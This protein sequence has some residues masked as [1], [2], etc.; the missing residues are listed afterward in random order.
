[1]S[2]VLLVVMVYVGLQLALGMWVSRRVASQQDYLLGGRSLGL[3]LC[4]ASMFATWFGAETCVGAA[5]EVYRHGLGAVSADP[6]GYGVCLIAFGLFIAAELRKRRYTTLADLFAERFSRPVER[7]VA[8]IMLPGSVLWAA[9]QI[10]AFGHV[11]ASASHG[12]DPNVGIAIAAA[13]TILYTGS[14]GLLADVYTDLLQGIVLVITLV[15]LVLIIVFGVDSLGDLLAH[16]SATAEVGV[17]GVTNAADA[18]DMAN[19]AGGRDSAS[20]FAILNDWAVPIAGSLFTQEIISRAVASKTAVI[21]RRSALIAGAVYLVLGSIPV[22]LGLVARELL[23]A[24]DAVEQILPLLSRHLLGEVGFV[25]LAGALVSAILSTVDSALLAC[26]ALIVQNLVGERVRALP[27]KARLRFTRASVVALGVVAFGLATLGVS[28]HSLVEE[29]AALG[30][31]G[32]FV[33]GLLG[34]FTR[35]GGARAAL[36]SIL[37]GAACYV[38]AEHIL[39]SDVSYLLSL[40]GALIGYTLGALFEP[41][42]ATLS[43][44]G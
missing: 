6:F 32:L 27:D 5:G 36:W 33:A 4:T 20:S 38:Y 18:T 3:T 14:G 22:L 8:L 41:R 16:A 12:L 13:I 42:P 2:L 17:A 26:G 10:R 24:T 23:P 31:S 43:A 9:A 28:V 29:S 37:L 34:L 44:A 39:E 25:I 21:A 35:L 7:V 1:M 19:A 40:A 30:S 11:F 15:A